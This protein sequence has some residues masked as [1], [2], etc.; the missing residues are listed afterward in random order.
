MALAMRKNFVIDN[1]TLEALLIDN[2]HTADAEIIRGVLNY[3]YDTGD[4]YTDYVSFLRRGVSTYR[5]TKCTVDTR[6]FERVVVR[7]GT[8]DARFIGIPSP[9]NNF[10]KPSFY[11][12][13]RFYF[14]SMEF[15]HRK[16]SITKLVGK[17]ASFV[18][19]VENEMFKSVSVNAMVCT[20]RIT[21][22]KRQNHYDV[23]TKGV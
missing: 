8:R 16:I 5:E 3:V 18:A 17:L 9:N 11:E 23:F 21:L 4:L 2:Y 6:T 15:E 10:L 14:D 13:C 20:A 12:M 7:E 19:L 1:E 22:T